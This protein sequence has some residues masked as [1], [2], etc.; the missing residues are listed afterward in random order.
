MA[1]RSSLCRIPYSTGTATTSATAI[2]T[3]SGR[4]RP[5]VVPDNQVKIFGVS[6]G[7]ARRRRKVVTALSP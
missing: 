4:V 7:L 5:Y 2:G 6:Y 3:T 1:M